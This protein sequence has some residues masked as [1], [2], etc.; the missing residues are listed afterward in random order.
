MWMR[1]PG[2]P[3]QLYVFKESSKIGGRMP[4]WK[5]SNR[6]KFPR[7]IFPCLIK[8]TAMD[9]EMK[10][11]LTHTEN[12]SMGGVRLLIRNRLELYLPVAIELDLMDGNEAVLCSGRIVWV[13]QRTSAQ[14]ICFDTGI[15]IGN[16][17]EKD[18]VRV[19]RVLAH[20]TKQENPSM[21]ELQK[22]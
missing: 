10:T 8:L 20:F 6:R 3:G 9:K 7:V 4:N 18:R 13:N 15:E 11:I 5:G 17:S 16:F 21:L 12:F 14:G 1:L 22:R 19:N 2:K